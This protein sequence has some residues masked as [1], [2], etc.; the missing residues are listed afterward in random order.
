MSNLRRRRS[1]LSPAARRRVSE[2]RL[3]VKLPIGVT[4]QGACQVQDPDLRP[5]DRL[6]L[7]TDGTQ[8]CA[9]P[10]PSTCPACC[11]S[12][13]PREVVPTRVGDR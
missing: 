7:H 8:E 13:H 11:A 12:P 4:H 1:T 2:L 10:M 3:A 9:T 6:L 5:G